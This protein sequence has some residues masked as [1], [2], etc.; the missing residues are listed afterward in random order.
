V[1]AN[2]NAATYAS[3]T[4]VALTANPAAGWNFSGWSG[5]LTGSANPAT[6]A[7]L[8]GLLLHPRIHRTA[9]FGPGGG[10]GTTARRHRWGHDR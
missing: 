4:V 5:N 8:S 9:A 7:S 10:S 2:P 6:A 1:S 3:D